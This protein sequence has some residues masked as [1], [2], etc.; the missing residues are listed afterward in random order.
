MS[1]KCHGSPVCVYAFKCDANA[2]LHVQDK[3]AFS[4]VYVYIVMCVTL[5]SVE[6]YQNGIALFP[7]KYLFY[8]QQETK[9]NTF[10]L[11]LKMRN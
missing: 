6:P 2:L 8:V 11:L 9:N 10:L 5:V 3:Q 1:P 4:F 7:F